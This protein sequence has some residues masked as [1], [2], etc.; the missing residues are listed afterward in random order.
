MCSVINLPKLK[1]CR[2]V[3]T[4]WFTVSSAACLRACPQSSLCATW[5]GQGTV[6]AAVMSRAALG[7][8]AIDSGG[9][10]RS[11][12]F[13]TV[14]TVAADS[15][16][17]SSSSSFAD[18]CSKR[19][20]C[21]RC[22]ERSFC[23]S[24]KSSWEVENHYSRNYLQ[25][26]KKKCVTPRAAAAAAAGG[27]GSSGSAIQ[28]KPAASANGALHEASHQLQAETLKVR[29]GFLAEPD[30]GNGLPMELADDGGF[31]ETFVIR[32]YEVGTT[33]TASMETIANLLQVGH[34][35]NQCSTT[36]SPSTGFHKVTFMEIFCY[37]WKLF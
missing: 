5:T 4:S 3:W 16:L 35:S 26:Q 8:V 23:G 37:L 36:I 27:G 9:S 11:S 15:I 29:K 30:L 31:R 34:L 6:M 17:S 10:W 25:G 2:L 1:I 19:T 22:L 18:T 32:C 20:F 33:R 7:H 28:E 21:E 12:P 24:S 14:P 13:Q